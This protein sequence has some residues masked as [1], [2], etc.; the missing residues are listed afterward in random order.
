[1]V[2]GEVKEVGC[3]HSLSEAI[4]SCGPC[5]STEHL[6]SRGA[7]FG[8]KSPPTWGNC[9]QTNVISPPGVGN[10]YTKYML[11]SP[12]L[13]F[14][15]SLKEEPLKFPHL[16][17][18]YKNATF[19]QTHVPPRAAPTSAFDRRLKS[20]NTSEHPVSLYHVPGALLFTAERGGRWHSAPNGSITTPGSRWELV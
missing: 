2:L 18:K 15:I 4:R 1:M 10:D 20:L 17:F 6:A 14:I 9:S 5:S 13:A 11:S 19:N 12:T 8:E 7:V 16:R 3:R